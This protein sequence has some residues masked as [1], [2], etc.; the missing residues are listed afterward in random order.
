MTF[1][2]IIDFYQIYLCLGGPVLLDFK[3]GNSI[4]QEFTYLMTFKLYPLGYVICIWF[5]CVSSPGTLAIL[6]RQ[7]RRQHF[8]VIRNQ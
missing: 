4:S 2:I 7:N 8:D 1:V 6:D 3:R 5:A